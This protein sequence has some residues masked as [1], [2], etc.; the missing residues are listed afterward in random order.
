MV[1]LNG[2]LGVGKTALSRCAAAAASL[3]SCTRVL[4]MRTEDAA[5]ALSAPVVRGQSQSPRTRSSSGSVS[6]KILNMVCNRRRSGFLRRFFGNP[7]LDVPSPSYL[8]HFTYSN[9][10]QVRRRA[11]PRAAS[12]AGD[13]WRETI[14]YS[15]PLIVACVATSSSRRPPSL[16]GRR[17]GG[18]WR[19]TPRKATRSA[20][21]G[22]SP[23]LG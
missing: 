10:K 17:S 22:R 20:V 16:Q 1:F 3:H 14:G 23:A 7:T 18:E 5:E 13:Y 4:R 6:K 12:K 15:P 8:L 9:A 19:K 21:P 11:S 2:D